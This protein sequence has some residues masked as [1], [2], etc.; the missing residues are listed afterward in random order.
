M[1]LIVDEAYDLTKK[2]LNDN[3][4]KL[5]YVAKA[6]LKYETLD[7]D[8]FEKAFNET[9]SLDNDEI[10]IDEKKNDETTDM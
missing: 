9:L 6:L 10:V 4:S 3:M 5:H 7:A 1:K 2:L 8:Q